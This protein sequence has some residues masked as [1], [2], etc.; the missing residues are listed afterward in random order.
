VIAAFATVYLVW[1]STFLA[2]RY[3]IETIPP[4]TMASFRFLLAGGALYAWARRSGATRPTLR[5]WGLATL[6]GSLLFL[7]GNGSVVYAEKSVPSGVVALACGTVPL[8]MSLFDS[9][10]RGRSRLPWTTW[11]AIPIG[12]A[13]IALLV[14]PRKLEGTHGTIDPAMALL[15]LAGSAG[16]GGASILARRHPL[17]TSPRAATGMQMLGG[18]ASLAL[19]GLAGGEWSRFVPAELSL[20]STL[21]LLYL[22]GFGSILAFSAYAWL[23]RV[24]TP[25]RVGTYAWV[26]PLVAVALGASIGGEP[27]GARTVAAGGFIVAAVALTTIGRGKVPTEGEGEAVKQAG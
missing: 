18:G 19:A 22:V 5:D 26:N 17:S 15:L 11:G 24:S 13:G 23:L 20:R 3:A 6:V 10:G 1:G 25:S 16:W 8:W 7:A 4:L 2:I 9:I 27:I 14:E 21:S 12:F